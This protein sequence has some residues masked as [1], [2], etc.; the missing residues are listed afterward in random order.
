VVDRTFSFGND[1]GQILPIVGSSRNVPMSRIVYVLNGLNLNLLGKRQPAIYDYE[2]LADVE[3]A[4]RRVGQE[5]DLEIE[6]H[7]NTMQVPDHR[8]DPRGP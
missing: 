5:L 3:A 1:P 4:C 8:L 6:F 7:Q 2:T